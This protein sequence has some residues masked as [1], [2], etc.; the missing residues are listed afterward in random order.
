MFKCYRGLRSQH[1]KRDHLELSLA[2]LL[3]VTFLMRLQRSVLHF[4][5]LFFIFSLVQ[6]F[7]DASSNNRSEKLLDVTLTEGGMH[8]LIERN[9]EENVYLAYFIK[10]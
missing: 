6:D 9:W 7:E 10:G 8:S 3:S 2:P 1:L 4:A 5:R